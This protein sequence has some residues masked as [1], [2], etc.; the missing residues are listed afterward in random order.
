MKRCPM[1]ESGSMKQGQVPVRRTVDGVTF[2]G[3]VP[4]LVCR[5]CGEAAVGAAELE[6]FELAIAAQ[7]GTMGRCTPESFRFTR[8]ALGL[9]GAALAELL[10]VEP[11][12]VSRWEN[13][14][15][16]LDRGAF[17]LLGGLVADRLAGRTDTR[18]RLEALKRPAKTPRTAVK[19][20][21]A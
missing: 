18:T 8:K 11:E 9:T 21:A 10:G 17:A 15:R 13:G 3:E 20:D 4:A 19:V 1:C 14:K 2:R 6:R 12:T 7:F 16:A 5:K